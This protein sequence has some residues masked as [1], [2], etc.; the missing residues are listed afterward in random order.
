LSVGVSPVLF[1]LGLA[2]KYQQMCNHFVKK[3]AKKVKIC[4]AMPRET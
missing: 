4:L 2:Q 3:N 1:C